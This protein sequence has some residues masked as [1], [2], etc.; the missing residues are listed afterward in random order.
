[1]IFFPNAKINIGLFITSKRADGYHNLES[2]FYPIGL[3]DI[4]EIKEKTPNDPWFANT[5]IPV[6]SLPEQNLCY[7]A[8][9][10]MREKYHIPPVTFHLHKIIPFGA[11]LGGGSSDAAFT[12]KALNRLFQLNLDTPALKKLALQLG[13]DCPFFIDNHPAFVWEK[14]NRMESLGLSIQG[15]H[16]VVVVPPLIIPT[17]EAY[18]HVTP[19]KR[20]G[21]LKNILTH[22]PVEKWHQKVHNDFEDSVFKEKPELKEIKRMLYMEGA[23]FASMS[24]S[25]SA[26]YGIFNDP[27]LRQEVF[28]G[29]YV[30]SGQLD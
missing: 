18:R 13:S 16:V 24:G 29:Y 2:V 3:S 4:L 11:G 10:L 1:M 21:S 14:G 19:R 22:T 9:E 17:P 26:V 7:R 23:L 5:G 15:K 30:W 27:P 12:L 28:S 6:D 20:A 25:G 8:F